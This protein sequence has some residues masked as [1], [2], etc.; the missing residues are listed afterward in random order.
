MGNKMA[1]PGSNDIY[2]V[3]PAGADLTG[4]EGYGIKFNASSQV[5]L[6]DTLGE[7]PNG[8]LVAGDV[9][10]ADVTIQI[11]G[12]TK[13]VASASGIKIGNSLSVSAAA[14]A[15]AAATGEFIFAQALENSSSDGH[16]IL[17]DIINAGK[18]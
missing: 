6:C 10:G 16:R 15:K 8:V 9:A 18:A 1:I 17:V 7:R 14:K 13:M 5:V 4:K 12:Q 11:K 3:F 2:A